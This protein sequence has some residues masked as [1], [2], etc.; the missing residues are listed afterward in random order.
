MDLTFGGRFDSPITHTPPPPGGYRQGLVA[1]GFTCSPVCLIN[2]GWSESALGWGA[3][4]GVGGG[5]WWFDSHFDDGGSGGP[6]RCQP[7]A[8]PWPG[9]VSGRSG[10]QPLGLAPQARPGWGPGGTMETP[11]RSRQAPPPV[12][13]PSI[14]TILEAI[15]LPHARHVSHHAGT[16]APRQDMENF[17]SFLLGTGF[18]CSF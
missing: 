2:D 14:V 12:P 15:L 5:G 7:A 6:L 10:R 3:V 13:S 1:G 8:R 18:L 9:P 16:S 4:G 17:P 11:A